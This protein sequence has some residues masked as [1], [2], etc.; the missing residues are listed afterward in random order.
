MKIVVAVA[1]ALLSTSVVIKPALSQGY[2]QFIDPHERAFSMEIPQ[3]WKVSGGLMRHAPTLAKSVMVLTSPDGT[4][5]QLGDPDITLFVEPG[6][7]G[8]P[9][10][11]SSYPIGQDVVLR[12]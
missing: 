4:H 10:E 1:V 6:G 9:P 5:I 2:V 12:V 8:V 7:Y 3:G 11:G